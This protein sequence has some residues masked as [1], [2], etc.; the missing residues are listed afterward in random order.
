MLSNYIEIPQKGIAVCKTEE[1]DVSGLKPN[2]AIIQ[3]EATM[4]S[5]G[6]ELS[7]V[8]E[9]KKGFRYPVRPGY[10]AVGRVLD[11]G[12]AL[13]FEVGDK[14]F[15][16]G[17]HASVCRFQNGIHTQ[18]PMMFKL[19]EDIDS[20]EATIIT[21]GLVAMNGISATEIQLGDTLVVFGLGAIGLIAALLYQELGARVIAVD[22]VR[23][24][25]RLAAELGIKEV[26]DTPSEEQLTLIRQKTGGRGADI[27]VD[28]TGLSPVIETAAL[29]CGEHGQVILLGT[30]RAE[31]TAN[32]TPML[33][34]IHMKMLRVVGAFNNLYPVHET[35][36]SR[37]SV[38]RAFDVILQR[39][40][41]K[42][43]DAAKFISHIITPAQAQ[44][45]YHGLMFDKE[46]YRCV[47]IDWRQN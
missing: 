3:A 35:E 38:S 5:A 32:M 10:C 31:Y 43:I 20:T 16:T 33:N 13:N 47:V 8:F 21:L 39:V 18:G 22:P 45:A 37:L 2:E 29:C 46:N 40:R 30:P 41:D 44:E 42:R 27:A 19:P 6:T 36:G 15:Y 12:D 4:I 17:P 34:A 26:F 25:C 14:V 1:I 23:S 28:V 11:K 9:I 24:R 7:R